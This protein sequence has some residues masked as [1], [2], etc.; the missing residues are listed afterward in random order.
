MA[1]KFFFKGKSRTHSPSLLSEQDQDEISLTEEALDSSNE[2]FGQTPDS[3]SVLGGT[4]SPIRKHL[5]EDSR[6]EGFRSPQVILDSDSSSLSDPKDL[7]RDLI[8][9]D[10]D[11]DDDD[12]P[13]VRL[14]AG[15]KR[16][17][18][19]LISSDSEEEEEEISGRFE[20]FSAESDGAALNSSLT[21][22]GSG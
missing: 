7:H 9:E 1:A 15:S 2:M 18:R 8:D 3:S 12:V 6:L 10:E 19:A 21:L 20:T 4:I 14:D 22:T 5:P 16:S 17:Q 13:L 11:S